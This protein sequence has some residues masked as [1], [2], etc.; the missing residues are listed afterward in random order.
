MMSDALSLLSA[1]L[2]VIVAK[3]AL[4]HFEGWA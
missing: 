2:T 1:G 4:M 3:L